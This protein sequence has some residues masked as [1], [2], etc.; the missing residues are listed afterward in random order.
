M[1][2]SLLVISCVLQYIYSRR[3]K[4]YLII[5]FYYRNLLYRLKKIMNRTSHTDI[6]I[7]YGLKATRTTRT[8]FSIKNSFELMKRTTH[9]WKKN[10]MTKVNNKNQQRWSCH[11]KWTDRQA[12]IYRVR[13]IAFFQK[14]F[15]KNYWI[16]SQI[17]FFI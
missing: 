14:W 17:Y 12:A 16:F 7:I 5:W 9:D 10:K 3:L 6:P 13:Q 4:S 11:I 15:K 1:T 2:I 8:W